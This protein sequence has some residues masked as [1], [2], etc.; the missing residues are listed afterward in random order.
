MFKYLAKSLFP[1]I[2][3][4]NIASF[5]M[6]DLVNLPALISQWIAEN[7]I[8]IDTSN[9]P[10]WKVGGNV[11]GNTGATLGT[12]DNTDLLV[13]TDSEKRWV[14]DKKGKFFNYNPD[15]VGNNRFSYIADVLGS[16]DDSIFFQYRTKGMSIGLADNGVGNIGGLNI[17]NGEDIIALIDLDGAYNQLSDKSVKREITTMTKS[18]KFDKLNPVKFKFNN[19]DAQKRGFIAQ[20]VQD[21]Y[22]EL[23]AKSGE[24]LTVNY[25]GLIPVLV[26]E[27]Q[28]TNS[29]LATLKAEVKKLKDKNDRPAKPLL[30]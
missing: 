19:S 5:G 15:Y 27:L 1:N 10:F 14:F 28:H 6:T 17:Y 21:V 7:V 22:P 4:G 2:D 23:V 29:E 9:Y 26:A 24:T 8:N 11:I 20:E 30:K 3:A 25:T 16:F 18:T 13:K 12:N